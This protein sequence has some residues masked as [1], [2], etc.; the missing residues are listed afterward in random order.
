MFE[1]AE[2]GH[3]IDREEYRRREPALRAAL[4]QLPNCRGGAAKQLQSG[5]SKRPAQMPGAFC[6]R[7][8]RLAH[9]IPTEEGNWVVSEQLSKRP[10]RR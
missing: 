8:K 3:R 2:V 7:A 1:S 9:C 6:G 4:L 5:D 10:S